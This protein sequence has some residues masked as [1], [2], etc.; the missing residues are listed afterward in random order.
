MLIDALNSLAWTN[1]IVAHTYDYA[2]QLMYRAQQLD[3]ALR[4]EAQNMLVSP[5]TGQQWIFRG[6]NGAD[7]DTRGIDRENTA[8]FY[9]H[10]VRG[11]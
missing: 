3:P 1:W 5:E 10:F 8:V 4:Q 6:V 9:D 2:R 7:A 11:V